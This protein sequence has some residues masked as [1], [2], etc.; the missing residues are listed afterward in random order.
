MKESEG[1]CSVLGPIRMM[2]WRDNFSHWIEKMA[3]CLP[4]GRFR[5]CAKGSHVPTVGHAAQFVTCFA[6]KAAWQAG[7][8]DSWSQERKDGCINLLRSFQ[9][10]EGWFYDPWL[11]KVS[12]PD[13]RQWGGAILRSIRGKVNWSDLTDRQEMNLRAETR[14]SVSTLIM[15][16][17]RPEYPLPMPWKTPDDI[18]HFL[19]GLD[20]RFPWSAGSHLSHLAFILNVNKHYFP[21]VS[22][23][24]SL[25]D[26][27]GDFLSEI[28]D[29]ESGAW[30]LGNV[31]D[32]EKINGAMKVLTAWQWMDHP[33]PDCSK[34]LDLALAQ[35]C[36]EDGCGFLNRLFVVYAARGACPPGYC[37]G[38]IKQLAEDSLMRISRFEKSDG[39][40]SF[41]EE[42]AQTRYYG[43][44]VSE[45]LPVSDMHGAAMLVWAIA[46]AI[47]LMGDDAPSGSELWRAHRT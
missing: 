34:L 35:P 18:L 27:L 31:P 5:F 16:K 10:R 8:W 28:R 32:Q 39:G 25:F 47:E 46:L 6:M 37:T 23:P 3:T 11:E 22:V 7:L 1:G 30:F 29:D 4:E 33:L 40:F 38:E 24:Q 14:Q 41:Y 20:W 17:A 42:H 2:E 9:I 36:L 15:V 43:A 26:A 44:R 19:R 13:L 12:K 21:E 45:G